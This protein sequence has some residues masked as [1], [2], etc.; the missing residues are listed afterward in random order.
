MMCYETWTW[1]EC[2]TK[3]VDLHG[4]WN[5]PALRT[6]R[7]WMDFGKGEKESALNNQTS[8]PNPI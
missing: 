2:S 3:G 8:S 4:L 5:G 1:L 6:K 7:I